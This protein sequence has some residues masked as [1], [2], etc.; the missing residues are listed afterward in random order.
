MQR[1]LTTYGTT[2]CQL[3]IVLCA[4]NRIT[5]YGLNHVYFHHTACKSLEQM[6][7][8]SP[9][10]QNRSLPLNNYAELATCLI[11]QPRPGVAREPRC[12]PAD[13][14]VASTKP[15]HAGLASALG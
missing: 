12:H 6:L 5:R 8:I 15:T 9:R 1:N 10:V 11:R 7:K 3:G 13:P 2:H 4:H 14:I